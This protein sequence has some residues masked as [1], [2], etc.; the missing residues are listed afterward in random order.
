MSAEGPQVGDIYRIFYQTGNRHNRL[1]HVRGL[2]DTVVVVRSWSKRY[3]EWVYT[4]EPLWYF[5]PQEGF[6][7][8]KVK[9]KRR[10]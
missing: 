9:G 1:I 3:Q 5:D 10:P 2:I 7:L 6:K 8:T 4:C